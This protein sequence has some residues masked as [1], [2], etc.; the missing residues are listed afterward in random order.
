MGGQPRPAFSGCQRRRARQLRCSA[1]GHRGA[2]SRGRPPGIRP[3]GSIA[4]ADVVANGSVSP[5]GFFTI[6][7]RHRQSIRGMAGRCSPRSNPHRPF[8]EL[9][10]RHPSR[11]PTL[12]PV[13][14][15]TTH[16]LDVRFRRGR[17]TRPP[18]H[19]P[20][21]PTLRPSPLD[22]QRRTV[23]THPIPLRHVLHQINAPRRVAGLVVVPGHHLE[24][25]LVQLDAR[26]SIENR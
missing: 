5:P 14:V 4:I 16:S 8:S 12:S 13:A 3:R 22:Q 19:V 24:E 26:L 23:S 11:R 10:L 9:S 1:E 18:Y 17:A 21:L 6:K 25:V 7:T 20:E 2:R 15:D